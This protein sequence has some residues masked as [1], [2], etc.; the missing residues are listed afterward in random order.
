MVVRWAAKVDHTNNVFVC[1]RTTDITILLYIKYISALKSYIWSK[2]NSYIY[3]KWLMSYG[4][5][6]FMIH[7][8]TQKKKKKKR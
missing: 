1:F 5:T 3:V 4:G 7:F 6:K 8:T 2:Y